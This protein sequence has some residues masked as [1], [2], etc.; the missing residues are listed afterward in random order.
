MSMSMLM[1]SVVP[2]AHT[3]QRYAPNRPELAEAD[4]SLFAKRTRVEYPSQRAGA[5]I[6]IRR[7]QAIE[8]ATRPR[9]QASWPSLFSEKNT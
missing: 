1:H 3:R 4:L 5:H 2:Q 6:T 8:C 7:K 9:G